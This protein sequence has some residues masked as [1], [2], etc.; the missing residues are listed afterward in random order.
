VVP[1]NQVQSRTNDRIV[2][3]VDGHS[4]SAEERVRSN[5]HV[6]SNVDIPISCDKRRQ[7]IV[8]A[9]LAETAKA[10]RQPPSHKR[11]PDCLTKVVRMHS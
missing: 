6:A 4:I 1:S 5:E 10:S 11:A 8:R 3:N 7:W 2:A 9:P